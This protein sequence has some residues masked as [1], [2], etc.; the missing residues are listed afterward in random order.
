MKKNCKNCQKEFSRNDKKYRMSNKTWENMNYC[1]RLCNT[2]LI[3]LGRKIT[4]EHRI[5]LVKSH[6]GKIHSGSFKKGHIMKGKLSGNWRGGITKLSSRIRNS[7]RYKNWRKS[8]FER[9]N[10]TCVDC[11]IIGGKLNADHIQPFSYLMKLYSVKSFEDAMVTSYLW[12]LANG[13]T[14]CL[15]CHKQTPTYL[16]PNNNNYTLELKKN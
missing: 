16:N 14:L 12:I 5:N 10:Y 1:S 7:E 15:E 4:D 11:G 13:R 8:I 2:Q 9:D 3:N 6:I